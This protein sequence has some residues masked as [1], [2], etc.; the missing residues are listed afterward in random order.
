MN[1]QYLTE[2]ASVVALTSGFNAQGTD[3]RVSLGLS[4]PNW[5]EVHEALTRITET[6]IEAMAADASPASFWGVSKDR[7]VALRDAHEALG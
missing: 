7:L 2:S 1:Y 4:S 5:R 3:E 6:N